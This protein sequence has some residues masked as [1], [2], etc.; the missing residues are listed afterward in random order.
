MQKAANEVAS[1]LEE[2][3]FEINETKTMEIIVWF[4]NNDDIPPLE[5]NGK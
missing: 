2:N 3:R 4:G 1:W 5:L